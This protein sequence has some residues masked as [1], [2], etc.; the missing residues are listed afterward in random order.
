[1]AGIHAAYY[2]RKHDKQGKI[3]ILTDEKI[4]FYSRPMI[5]DVMTGKRTPDEIVLLRDDEYRVRN[6]DLIKG[7]AAV[8]INIKERIMETTGGTLAFRKLLL[9][10]GAAPKALPL[11]EEGIFYLRTVRDAIA[12]KHSLGNAKRV[13]ISGG[14]PVGIKAAYALLGKNYPVSVIVG[15]SRILSRVLDE[16]AAHLFQRRLEEHGARFYLNT[17]IKEVISGGGLKGVI[18]ED[19]REVPGDMLIVG[20]GVE[21]NITLA[22]DC[23][24]EIGRGI[25]TND[26]METNL[27][28]VFAAGDVTQSKILPDTESA[29][30]GH[31]VTDNVS[32][33][34]IGSIQGEV[35]GTNMAGK[36]KRFEGSISANSLECF[37]MRTISMGIL[38]G[39]G[40]E[41][42]EI[43]GKDIYKRFLFSGEKL[44]GAI[45]VGDIDG[46][47]T[48]LD[49]IRKGLRVRNKESLFATH[50]QFENIKMEVLF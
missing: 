24:V 9:S 21:P 8:R 16:K 46:A 7:V 47:G 41:K 10:T 3:A 38:D 26:R 39:R 33:W 5:V 50:S 27:P 14:G 32:L 29:G 45:L 17:G 1:M 18:T 34:Y 6:F 11:K 40:Y 49:A 37:G 28:D 13:V 31:S 42:V 22:E 12:I 43:E 36:Q 23:G 44:V 48:I 25:A 15:S 30:S 35:A 4:N 2:I 19:N 20:K